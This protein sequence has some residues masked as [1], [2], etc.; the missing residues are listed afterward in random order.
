MKAQVFFLIV[1]LFIINTV[2]SQTA[3]FTYILTVHHTTLL[4]EVTIV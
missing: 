4:Q 1:F 3:S 2:Q